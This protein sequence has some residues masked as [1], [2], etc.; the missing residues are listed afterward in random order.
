MRI[1]SD[2]KI[3]LNDEGR[4]WRKQSIEY[5]KKQIKIKRMRIKLKTKYKLNIPL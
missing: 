5:N 4:N 3:K 2:I 1:K